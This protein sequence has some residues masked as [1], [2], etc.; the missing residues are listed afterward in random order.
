MEDPTIIE[1]FDLSRSVIALDNSGTASILDV[2]DGPPQRVDGYTISAPTL[3]RNAPHRGEMHPDGDEVLYVISG[4]VQVKL[5]ESGGDR[6][7]SVESGQSLIVPRGVWHL[8]VLEEPTHLL[9]IT[10]GPG[11]EHRP[12]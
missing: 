8:V 4:R 5:E 9:H 10:P 6:T 1:P 3:T 12:L 11:G 7:V 2:P